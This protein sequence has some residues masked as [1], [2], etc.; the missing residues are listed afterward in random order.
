MSDMGGIQW[1]S[2][3]G[4]LVDIIVF[5]LDFKTLDQSSYTPISSTKH[6]PLP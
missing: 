3:V 4:Y 5:V 2:R 1:Y 6:S